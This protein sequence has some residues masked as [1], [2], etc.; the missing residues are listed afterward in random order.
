MT[1]RKK[2]VPKGKQQAA[3]AEPPA[4]SAVKRAQ[5][6][7]RVPP[8]VTRKPARPAA[9][10]APEKVTARKAPP[11]KRAT[12]PKKPA[13]GVKATRAKAKPKPAPV[14][15]PTD[16]RPEYVEKIVEFFNIAVTRVDEAD[17]TDGDGKPRKEKSVVVNTFPT[18]T[19]YASL[20]G[21]TRETLHDWAT[22]KGKDGKLRHPEF[23]YAY[24]R[25]KDLQESLLVEGGMAGAYDSR[26]ATLAAKNL[27]GWRDQAEVKNE[28]V[29]NTT[30]DADLDAIYKRKMEEVERQT[31]AALA[32]GADKK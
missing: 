5:P 3:K 10:V 25:A 6:T 27:A 29:F 24:A 30:A 17:V 12:V 16:Y 11:A 31:R 9:P 8:K 15:R 20:I 32:R 18:L 22:G 13:A 4:A 2:P 7:K 14:G 21:V 28:H 26:F 1:E 23:S 19:R